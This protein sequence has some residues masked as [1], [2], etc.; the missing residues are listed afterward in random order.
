MRVEYAI[1][2]KIRG[3]RMH[4][5]KTRTTN[6]VMI[7]ETEYNQL[8]QRIGTPLFKDGLRMAK[9]SIQLQD[10]QEEVRVFHDTFTLPM[11]RNIFGLLVIEVYVNHVPCH[12]I[13]DTGA[14]ISGIRSQCMMNVNASETKGKLGVGSVGGKEQVVKGCRVDSLQ[15]GGL[16]YINKAMI[17]L[18]K[19]TFS[20]GF[21][22]IDLMNFDGILGWDVLSTLDFEM[23]DIAKEFKVLKNVYRFP[24]K[25]MIAG[26]F[27]VFLCKNGKKETKVFGFDSG[28]KVSW[29]NEDWVK[30]EKLDVVA[31][32]QALGFGVHGIERLP[33]KIIDTC[34]LYLDRGEITLTDTMTGRCNLFD[35]FTFDGV[36]G[37]QIFKGR[38]IRIVNSKQVVLL[39]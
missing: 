7:E 16:E 5:C 11:K 30:E 15:I 24:C 6:R 35:H 4:R 26:S 19:K 8:E 14:Q 33:M 18:D 32:G 39:V 3:D 38:R 37:N 17:V 21:G 31:T 28:S 12:F 10:F 22:N 2:E 27:P 23:D 25:N 36:F 13:I 9:E 34:T 1:I 29:L 20:I